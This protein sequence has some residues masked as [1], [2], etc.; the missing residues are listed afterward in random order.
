MNNRRTTAF[1]FLD[2]PANVFT[3]SSGTKSFLLIN[4]FDDQIQWTRN[5]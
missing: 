1:F 5:K 2:G 3:K 4:I